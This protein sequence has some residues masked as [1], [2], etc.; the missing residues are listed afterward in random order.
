MQKLSIRIRNKDAQIYSKKE[1]N[2][3]NLKPN[4]QIQIKSKFIKLDSII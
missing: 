1:K 4:S 3:D 2:R